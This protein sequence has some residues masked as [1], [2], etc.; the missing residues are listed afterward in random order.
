GLYIDAFLTG[1]LVVGNIIVG[2]FQESRAKRQLDRI[3]VLARSH[4]IVIRDGLQQEIDPGDIVQ[5]DVCVIGPGDQVQADGVVLAEERCSIDESLLTGESDL[6]RKNVDDDVYSGSFVMSGRAVY[7]CERVGSE[8][9]ANR[10]AENARAFRVIRTPLQR[11]VGWV[12]WGMAAVVALI[13]LEV[14]ASFRDI[15]GRV[16]LVETT[17]AAAVIVA[18][19]PQG[20]WVMVTVTYAMAIVRM[21]PLGTLVQRLNAVESISHVDVLCLDKTG[22]ITTN[23]LKLEELHALD[24][25]EPTLR[26]Q[27]G[28]YCASASISNRTN[29]AIAD[30]IPCDATPVRDEVHFDSKRKWSA[31]L[32]DSGDMRG[33]YVLG[34][35]EVLLSR[36]AFP[37]GSER[38]RAWSERG[39]RVLLFASSEDARSVDYEGEEPRLPDGLRPLGFVVLRDELRPHAREIIAQFAEGGIA[40]KII[41]GDNPGTVAALA[42]DAGVPGAERTISGLDLEGAGDADLDRIVNETTVFG[43]TAPEQK[44]R[45][46]EALQ[47]R[48][49]YVAMIGD[50]VN[51]VP[52][53]KRA[54]VA[55]SVKAGSPV[56][57]SIADLLLLDDSFSALPSAFEEGRRI[58]K[59]MEATVRLFL[60][61]TFSVALMILG[62]AFLNSEF[63]FTPR[64]TAIHST[65]TV[66]LPALFV[67]AWTKPGRTSRYLIPASTNFVAPAAALLGIMGI[68]VY[69]I[70]LRGDGVDMSRTV[71][72]VAALLAGIV[73]IPFVDDP[74]ADWLAMRGLMNPRWAAGVAGLML[75]LFAVVMAI[76]PFRRF[77]ELEVPGNLDWLLIAG[78]VVAW[79]LALM[80]TWRLLERGLDAMRRRRTQVSALI[81][82]ESTVAP[83]SER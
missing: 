65:L 26:S 52:A 46:V 61:R 40:L 48:G 73:L 79:T 58:R 32:F 42:R 23:A 20:L 12:M 70:A 38:V 10:I 76:D 3:S 62:V 60:V 43:R 33:V 22:T 2:V 47:R 57:R 54:Q 19:I 75:V 35:P 29:D 18:L 9:F 28:A 82:R 14:L 72:T 13:S 67:V 37:D 27:L 39:L 55:I 15:Y 5:G 41:S 16:P 50:G 21:S 66:G 24:V 31:L 45:I 53:L 6:V 63:P 1:A 56:T 7:R 59:G 77:Y 17:R 69:W 11:E 34:A 64:L 36:A 74:P 4:A 25:D 44:A 68:I 81:T 71:L 78:G 30:A 83:G 80:A 49:H 8:G 51:D